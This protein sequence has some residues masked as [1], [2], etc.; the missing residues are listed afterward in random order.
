MSVTV[1]KPGHHRPEGFEMSTL[2]SVEIHCRDQS[3]GPTGLTGHSSSR[4]TVH[5]IWTFW[6]GSLD[7]SVSE[8]PAVLLIVVSFA[9]QF[10]WGIMIHPGPPGPVSVQYS[11]AYLIL[12]IWKEKFVLC[13]LMFFWILSIL[14]PVLYS[15]S[16]NSVFLTGY[17][18]MKWPGRNWVLL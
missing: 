11:V 13:L 7:W 10:A 15:L 18:R 4:E 8:L 6:S 5:S 17:Y 14:I 16:T 3:R 12:F 1:V 9:V 2:N